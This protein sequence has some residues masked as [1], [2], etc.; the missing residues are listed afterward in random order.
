MV[1]KANHFEMH[2]ELGLKV[3]HLIRLL[4]QKLGLK[5]KLVIINDTLGSIRVQRQLPPRNF[6][7]PFFLLQI[8]TQCAPDPLVS[9]FLKQKDPP[10]TSSVAPLPRL[11]VFLKFY[12]FLPP[13]PVNISCIRLCY[14]CKPHKLQITTLINIVL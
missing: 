1:L 9:I 2:Y 5:E 3:K 12:I 14:W 7:T 10:L 4:M 11:H 6:Q 8:F 13:P